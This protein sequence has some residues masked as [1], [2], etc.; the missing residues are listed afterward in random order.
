[1]HYYSTCTVS[2]YA[3]RIQKVSYQRGS[4]TTEGAGDFRALSIVVLMHYG[5]LLHSNQKEL[6]GGFNGGVL[7]HLAY[8]QYY[9]SIDVSTPHWQVPPPSCDLMLERW[10]I[11]STSRNSYLIPV[12]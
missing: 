10:R 11:A 1:M 5:G 9:W 7:R 12:W 8:G 4:E 2:G 3:C 6:A